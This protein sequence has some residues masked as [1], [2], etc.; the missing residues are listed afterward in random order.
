MIEYTI[1]YNKVIILPIEN[2]LKAQKI[3]LQSINKKKKKYKDKTN[4]IDKI[5]TRMGL[6]QSNSN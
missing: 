6:D 2:H 1:F 5:T 3:W 4:I